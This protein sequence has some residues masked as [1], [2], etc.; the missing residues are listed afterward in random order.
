[1]AAAPA[2]DD[3]GED[4]SGFLVAVAVV[5]WIFNV[6]EPEAERIWVGVTARE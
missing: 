6:A 5:E 1:M 3:D 2:D 4:K